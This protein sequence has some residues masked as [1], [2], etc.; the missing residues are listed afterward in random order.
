MQRG[1]SS[2]RRDL[3]LNLLSALSELYT[4]YPYSSPEQPNHSQPV[5]L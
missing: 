4:P 3:Q 1:Y 5:W 2:L